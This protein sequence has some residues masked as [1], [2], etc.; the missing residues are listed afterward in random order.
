MTLL[1]R[2]LLVP[3]TEHLRKVLGLPGSCV[4]RVLRIRRLGTPI[5]VLYLVRVGKGVLVIHQIAILVRPV[6]VGVA[7]PA[8]ADTVRPF[9][10][11]SVQ[12]GDR[13]V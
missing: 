3:R 5:I 12:L 13:C 2:L 11:G 7:V 6:V 9:V 4:T 10:V 1:E 8:P